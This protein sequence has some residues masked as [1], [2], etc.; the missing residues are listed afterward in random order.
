[1]VICDLHH[2]S[3]PTLASHVAKMNPFADLFVRQQ[4]ARGTRFSL[5]SAITRPE[6]ASML[7]VAAS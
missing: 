3:F 1:M 2:F 6:S 7:A 5:T 4:Q